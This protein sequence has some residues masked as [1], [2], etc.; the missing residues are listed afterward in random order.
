VTW[1][2]LTL[3]AQFLF[4]VGAHVDKYLLSRFFKGSAPGSLIL[5]SSLFSLVVLPALALVAPAV[6]AIAPWHATILLVGGFLNITG[7][8]LSLYA[9]KREEASVVVTLFQM[10]PVFNYV[11]AYL[12]LGE[13]LTVVQVAAAVLIMAGA[14]V[15]SLDLARPRTSVKA[16]VFLT[17]ALASLLIAANAVLFK[18]VAVSEDFW[19]SSF[20]SYLSLAIVGVV[21]FGLVRSYRDQFLRTLRLNSVPVVGLNVSNEILAVVGYLMISYA[22]LLVPVALVSVLSGFQPMMVFAIGVLLTL[23]LPRVGR[24]D[25]SRKR[26]VQKLAAMAGMLL[27]TYLLNR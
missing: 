11:L 16:S 9:M 1:L 4:S 6:L 12:V 19:V 26:V 8:I 14:V 21:L 23:A 5:F 27:G 22:T 13:T 7:V 15:V 20:W 10:I 17:M 3:G 24:E 18:L 2:W 25:L